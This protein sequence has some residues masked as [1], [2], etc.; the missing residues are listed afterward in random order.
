MNRVLIGFLAGGI[1]FAIYGASAPKN[2]DCLEC[3]SDK[4]LNKTNNDGRV[5]S[6][7]VDETILKKSIHKTNA[8]HS[9]HS[10]ITTKHPDDEVP[11]KPVSCGNCHPHNLESYKGSIHYLLKEKG[12]EGAPDCKDCHGAH[13]ILPPTNPE[14]PLHFSKLSKTCGE[15]H[16]EA[17]K[18]VEISV[19][20]KSA[21]EGHKEAATCIDC[22]SEHK[23]E[24]LKGAGAKQISE[25]VCGKCH[26]SEQINTKF[27]IPK[28]R[29]TTFLESYHGLASHLGSTRAA[30][31]ASCHGYHK[32]LPSSN[33]ESTI[34]K[35][36]LVATCGK[37]HPGA[38]EKFA[39][40]KIHTDLSSYRDTGEKVNY[41][42]RKIYLILITTTIG[43][44]FL[45]NFLLWVKKAILTLKSPDRTIERLTK[46]MRI[47]HLL[48]MISF[49]YLAI[50]GFALKFPDSYLSLL[51]GNSEEFRRLSHRIAGI[52]LI[53]LGMY[54]L[55]FIFASQEGKRLLKDMLP[56]KKDFSDIFYTIKYFLNK[57]DKPRFGRFGYVEKIEYWAVVWGTIIMGITGFAIWFKIGVT[58]I[59]PRWVI[60]V[61]ITIHYYEAILACLAIIV[62]HFYHVIFDP[63]V[64]PMN[65]AWLDGK[66]SEKYHKERHPGNSDSENSKTVKSDN[67]E[68]KSE[69]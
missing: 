13:Q 7:Y 24:K 33:P 58:E 29:V 34:H 60:D 69:Q 57:C 64:Y 48:L 59:L 40:G 2:S 10:D 50:S 66:V 67:E 55:I 47:Q 37:C 62:W 61:A 18:E 68:R 42:V 27:G 15:C 49:I 44:F 51:L 16:P 12:E 65:W 9:C 4:T 5:I 46:Q 8:C 1:A 6:L 53:G 17:A 41:W 45:H 52:I 35:N 26:S 38:S 43:L 30:N 22:H 32:V 56:N 21:A 54:H 36:N 31:C 3:H 25:N 63:D 14:S 39:S 20:G 23:I 11:A 28:N 19:H